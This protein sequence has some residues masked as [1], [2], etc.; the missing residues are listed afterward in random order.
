MHCY[1]CPAVVDRMRKLSSCIFSHAS[2][3]SNWSSLSTCKYYRTFD[4][5]PQHSVQSHDPWWTRKICWSRSLLQEPSVRFAMKQKGS[6][7]KCKVCFAIFDLYQWS[8]STEIDSVISGIYRS[9]FGLNACYLNFESKLI[10][11][12]FFVDFQSQTTNKA[13]E[14]FCIVP[15]LS[16]SDP[17]GQQFRGSRKNTDT[18][19]QPHSPIGLVFYIHKSRP[20]HRW[21]STIYWY[22]CWLVGFIARNRKINK[23]EG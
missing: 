13:N 6:K 12:A 16:G 17:Q 15:F 11:I 5:C 23:E 4:K 21:K 10:S 2:S 3:N 1:A 22:W 14:I 19:H 9:W 8:A 18:S 20:S 7:M